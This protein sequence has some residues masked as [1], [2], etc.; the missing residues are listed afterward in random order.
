MVRRSYERSRSPK[1]G[2]GAQA[3]K[4]EDG[5]GARTVVSSRGMV[6]PLAFVVALVVVAA[7]ASW[8]FASRA[9]APPGRGG[10]DA[11][12]GAAATAARATTGDELPVGRTAAAEPVG[13]STP[14]ASTA[15]FEVRGRCVTS[16]NGE[17]VV[18]CAA[19]LRL[20][21]ERDAAREPWGDRQLSAAMTT[22]GDGAFALTTAHDEWSETVALR[23]S[24]DGFVP[25]VGRWPRPEAGT[26]VELGDV[27]MQPAIEVSGTVV[28]EAGEPIEGATL[29]FAYIAMTGEPATTSENMLRARSDAAGRFRFAS[30]V[31][32]GEWYVGA[33]DTGALVEPRSVKIGAHDRSCSLRVVVE[34]PDPAF[35]I[36]GKVV[37]EAGGPVAGV[38][39]SASGEG[40]LGRGVSAADGT[41]AVGRAG[42]TRND[43]KAGV[44]LSA[45]D[46]DGR[47]EFVAPPGDARLAWGQHGVELVMRRLAARAV[48]V[49]DA[50]GAPV[51]RYTL[52]AFRGRERLARHASERGVHAQGCCR[53]ERLRAGAHC[54]LVVPRDPQLGSTPLVPFAVEANANGPEIV[55]T[56]PDRVPLRVRVATPAGD[57]V[58]GSR[59]E[60]IQALGSEPLTSAVPVVPVRECDRGRNLAPALLAAAV[61]DARGEVT[62][63]AAPGRWTIRARGEAHVPVLQ[64]VDVA[65]PETRVTLAVQSAAVVHGIVGPAAALARLR[66]LG[67][68]DGRPVVV[69]LEPA[70][71]GDATTAEIAADGSYAAGALASGDYAVALRF[72]LR[73]SEVAANDVVE[74][75]ARLVL[76][77]GERR[78]LP[79]DV[80]AMLPGTVRGRVVVGGEPLRDVHCFLRREAPGGVQSFRVATDSDGRFLGLVPPGPYGFALTYPAQ[81]GPGWV[82]QVLDDTW[83]LAPGGEHEV[84]LVAPLR[85]VRVRVV[86][87]RDRPLTGLRAKVLRTGYSLPGGLVTDD[88]GWLEIYPAPNAAFELEVEVD[89]AVQQLG[90]IDLPPGRDDGAVVVRAQRG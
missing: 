15:T 45:S 50:R 20:E 12:R 56:V 59:V 28:D 47:F 18:G 82:F 66:E 10:D 65:A 31:H 22:A 16:G 46:P 83:R 86:D 35:T 2:N 39:L 38:R 90:P 49:V 78:E 30:P 34:R 9:T 21:A 64:P 77:P 89:G 72:R 79:V 6:R 37:D 63:A 70:Q 76:A 71:G 67:D 19:A 8:W 74:P 68:G 58:P 73:T 26:V 40:F 17:P 1:L 53:L 57:G 7:A 69:Q 5:R 4:N 23:L 87:A 32:P 88:D 84:A 61:T 24:A 52:F 55:V 33:E 13:V 60:L 85:R 62:L 43:G 80:A 41:F 25:R 27:V 11:G 54:L 42:P 81:P 29:V 14:T 44:S 51:E 48:R 75:V 3:S 36:T